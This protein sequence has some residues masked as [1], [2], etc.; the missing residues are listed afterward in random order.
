MLLN[1]K[2]FALRLEISHLN[3]FIH[4]ITFISTTIRAKPSHRNNYFFSH[5][6]VGTT[7]MYHFFLLTPP[8]TVRINFTNTVE[9]LVILLPDYQT[10][11]LRLTSAHASPSGYTT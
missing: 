11:P 3:I 10:S 4:I 7:Q 1:I 2:F 9:T 5:F 6:V 8:L